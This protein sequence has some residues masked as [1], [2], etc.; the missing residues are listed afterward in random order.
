[1]SICGKC[2]W[3]AGERPWTLTLPLHS[4]WPGN[5][6]SNWRLPPRNRRRRL[7]SSSLEV[8]QGNTVNIPTARPIP[9][10]VHFIFIGEAGH[11]DY[12]ASK[13]GTNKCVMKNIEHSK[14]FFPAMMYGLTMSLKNEIVKIAPK[15]R[16]NTIGPGWVRT[17]CVFQPFILLYFRELIISQWPRNLSRIQT[18]F[19][20]L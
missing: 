12:A 6:W 14:H 7:L 3:I 18:S 4:S 5:I 1:M 9:D 19:T 15:G 20:V 11:A 2:H 10:P 17:V 13:S 16:V 8:R